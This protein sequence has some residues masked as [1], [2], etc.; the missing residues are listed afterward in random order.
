[1][2]SGLIDYTLWDCTGQLSR[3]K[4][5]NGR[6]KEKEKSYMHELL[7]Q[8]Y[9]VHS[10]VSECT[11]QLSRRKS[12]KGREKEREKSNIHAWLGLQYLVNMVYVAEYQ[13]VT[14]VDLE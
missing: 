7:S 4:S 5:K 3:R 10:S 9:G 6:E 14:Y 12:K 2:S 11:G 8:Y 1:M 13:N